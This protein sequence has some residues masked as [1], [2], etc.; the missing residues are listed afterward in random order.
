[1][2]GH[3]LKLVSNCA[4]V[5]LELKLAA[6]GVLGPVVPLCGAIRRMGGILTEGG[7]NLG[8]SAIGLGFASGAGCRTAIL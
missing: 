5:N 1:M 8:D 4:N 3:S 2:L 6:G 7:S